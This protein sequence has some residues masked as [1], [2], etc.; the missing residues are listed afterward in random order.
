M[1]T[2]ENSMTGGGASMSKAY[3][4]VK[5]AIKGYQD[6]TINGEVHRIYGMNK[7]EYMN[8]YNNRAR[9]NRNR[10][11]PSARRSSPPLRRSARLS[12]KKRRA[13]MGGRH[14]NKKTRKNRK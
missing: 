6:V 4:K 9:S 3:K 12:E 14:K 7:Q 8:W 13:S 11:A 5:G 2:Q 10:S 1:E